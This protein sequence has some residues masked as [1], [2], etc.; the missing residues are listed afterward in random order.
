MLDLKHGGHILPQDAPDACDTAQAMGYRLAKTPPQVTPFDY[1]LPA[2]KSNPESRIPGDPAKVTAD[3]K[4]LGAAMVGDA[5]RR[6]P[7]PR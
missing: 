6:P 4:A 3:L 2:L 1:L 7:T 5:A